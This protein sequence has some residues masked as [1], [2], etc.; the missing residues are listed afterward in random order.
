VNLSGPIADFGVILAAGG[1]GTRFGGRNKLLAL[2]D[3]RPVFTYALRRLAGWCGPDALVLVTPEAELDAFYQAARRFC[4]EIAF[5]LVAGGATRSESVT[6]GLAA[7]PETVRYVAIHDAARPFVTAAMVQGGLASA[8]QGDGAIVAHPVTDTL[9]RGSNDGMI[10]ATV[11]R[12]ALW[13]VETPQIFPLDKL[14]HAYALAAGR[15]FTDDGGV[16]EAAGYRVKLLSTTT[17][18][19]KITYAQDLLLAEA[20]L[21]SGLVG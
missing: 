18:N 7:L 5:Q 8:R 20:L 2:L 15:E 13:A 19:L 11:D 3:Q 17:P 21:H 12:S 10:E 16:M 14:R 9:K 6:H 1:A 4:P